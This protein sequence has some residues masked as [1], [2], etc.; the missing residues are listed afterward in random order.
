MTSRLSLA[1]PAFAILATGFAAAHPARDSRAA[2]CESLAQLKL[3]NTTITAAEPVTSGWF[4]MPRRTQGMP[5]GVSDT[6]AKLPPFCR[7]TGVIAPTSDSHILFEAWLPLEKWNG[8]F[9]GV[10]NG[11]WAGD[12]YYF[13]LADQL[14]RG[15][16]SIATNTGHEDLTGAVQAK[17]AVGHPE[18]LIDF[19]YRADHEITVQ[20][21][22]LTQAFY[23]KAA[24]YSYWV[25]CSSGGYEGLMEAQRFPADYNGIVA[26]AP[27]NNFTRLMAGGLD[28]SLAL[29]SL[30]DGLFPRAKL[31]PLATAVLAACDAMDGVMDGILEDPRACTFDPASLRCKTDQDPA[32]CLTPA[33]SDAVRRVYAG[34]KHPSTG[35]Q[36]FPGFSPGSERGWTAFLDPSGPFPIVES[37]YKWLAFADSTWEL[38]TFDFTRPA[39]FQAHLKA[40]A[41]YAPILN[42]TNAD[43]RAFAQRGGKLIQWHGWAD[44]LIAP[45]NSIDYYE[46][47][48][49]FSG[50][51]GKD[52]GAALR[53]VQA[54][55]RMYMAPGVGHCSGGAGPNQFDLQA[56]LEKWVEAS[57]AP[58]SAV[59]THFTN[60]V[61]DRTRPLCPY[62]KVAAWKGEGDTNDAANFACRDP[63]AK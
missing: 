55:Y 19:A 27:A 42:A 18:Q 51:S 63:K 56:A 5:A 46:S 59:A 36:L 12:I 16:A 8:R 50:G 22:A 2:A 24:D 6:L 20:G 7:V 3:P 1:G 23:G 31:R 37:Y 60:R 11:G 49:S 45:Q 35:A 47:V 52:R 26:G 10:G 62:P 4:R 25:G 40:E 15:N 34:L 44:M 17:F 38:K 53:D 32:T 58:E 61:V 41:K 33:E 28:A 13:S 43:L 29:R 57:T 54:F 9:T 39:D 48:L 21:K 14:R 30:P